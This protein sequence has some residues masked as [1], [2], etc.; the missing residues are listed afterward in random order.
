MGILPSVVRTAVNILSS[1]VHISVQMLTRLFWQASYVAFHCRC[2]HLP[3]KHWTRLNSIPPESIMPPL[4]LIY[5]FSFRCLLWLTRQFGDVWLF[6]I[7]EGVS[8]LELKSFILDWFFPK[9]VFFITWPLHSCLSVNIPVLW[10][11]LCPPHH[12][13]TWLPT[14]HGPKKPIYFSHFFFFFLS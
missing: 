1:V 7:S 11:V 9:F 14:F 5:V 10:V 8:N 13:C 2:G 12:S 3:C 4:T 6:I